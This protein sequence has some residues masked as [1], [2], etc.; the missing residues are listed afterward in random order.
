MFLTP[1]TSP[2]VSTLSS[3]PTARTFPVTSSGDKRSGSAW[4][5]TNTG[6]YRR[7]GASNHCQNFCHKSSS[8][9]LRPCLGM[10]IQRFWSGP[11]CVVRTTSRVG[12]SPSRNSGEPDPD[13]DQQFVTPW[14]G[15]T[16]RAVQLVDAQ[17]AVRGARVKN[18]ITPLLAWPTFSVEL[19]GGCAIL[20]GVRAFRPA[21]LAGELW[22]QVA[23][24]D[25]I[26]PSVAGVVGQF[27]CGRVPGWKRGGP[28]RILTGCHER[29]TN[30]C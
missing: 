4:P 23:Q 5:S 3:R 1:T 28:G 13:F 20:L 21:G 29:N 10:L 7:T 11:T 24:R 8:R 30:P 9:S 14:N 18:G 12:P 22:L 15:V 26:R 6:S 19:I 17:N 25:I 27:D 16:Q 2:S